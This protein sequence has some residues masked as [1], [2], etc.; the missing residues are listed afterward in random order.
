MTARRTWP[1]AITD[2]YWQGAA[3]S[4][5]AQAAAVAGEFDSAEDLA[6]AIT[7]AREQ[8]AAL[9]ALAQAA[10][11]AG[12]FDRAGRLLSQAEDLACA[13]DDRYW[14]AAA[15]TPAVAQAAAA[16]GEF[17]RAEDLARAITDPYRQAAALSAVAQAAAAAGEFDQARRLL[18]QAEDL[19]RTITL[20]TEQAAALKAL[21]PTAAATG[22]FDRAV[23][24]ARAITD[25]YRQAEALSA[26]AQAAA[27]TGEFDRAGRLLSQAEDLART[28]T[29]PDRQAEALSALAQAAA[30]TGEFD[31]AGRLLSQAEDLARAITDPDRQAEALI[32]LAQLRIRESVGLPAGSNLL[33]ARRCVAEALATSSWAIAVGTVARLDHVAFRRAVDHPLTRKLFTIS[34]PSRVNPSV[35]TAA[36]TERSEWHN[37]PGY[38]PNRTFNGHTVTLE[39]AG[40]LI[41]QANLT[42]DAEILIEPW[43]SVTST[44]S[45]VITARPIEPR[46]RRGEGHL[47]FAITFAQSVAQQTRPTVVAFVAVAVGSRFR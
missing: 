2:P 43:L 16:T 37:G 24:L 1:C 11:V 46:T 40:S 45:T 33:K 42:Y 21:A 44:S 18:S 32:M 3:L 31:R 22:E 12:E 41:D 39:C 5:L 10:G 8:A 25:P 9:S 47:S 38:V 23:D 4:A 19:N 26:L 13:I 15:L 29:D 34:F 27:G 30:G 20:V 14:Q 36:R 35:R 17:D 28:I 6:R 7:N